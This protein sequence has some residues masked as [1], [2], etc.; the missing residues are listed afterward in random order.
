MS[1]SQPFLALCNGATLLIVSRIKYGDMP[2][3]VRLIISEGV[4][5][6]HATPWEYVN[7]ISCGDLSSMKLQKQNLKLLNLYGPTEITFG[8]SSA[9]ILY[10]MD[11]NL[12]TPMEIFPDCSIYIL[13]SKRQ[14]LLIGVPGEIH[15]GGAGVAEG[16]LNNELLNRERFLLDDHASVEYIENNWI[17]MHRSG[18]RGRLSNKGALIVEGRTD[19]DTQIKL[20][21]IR[22]DF[23]DI[24]STITQNV[25]G[26]VKQA[27]VSLFNSSSADKSFL[28]AHKFLINNSHK[29]DRKAIS[30]L[31]LSHKVYKVMAPVTISQFSQSQLID[32]WQQALG[33][34]IASHYVIEHNSN[35]F[36]VGGTSVGLIKLQCLIKTR[37]QV[38]VPLAQLFENL[39]L[40]SMTGKIAP[41]SVVVCVDNFP[42]KSM[43]NHRNFFFIGQ[44]GG[45]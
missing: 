45:V 34:E 36:Q 17:K 25:N 20:R 41:V 40:D 23:E 39:T 24:E 18:D 16:Y 12:Q 1:L 28:V 21:G 37:F 44:Q 35:L 29:V 31:P 5:F 2:A 33:T 3:I 14:P 32:L 9:E 26:A 22:F 8:M 6:T 43:A 30:G 13:N 4:T 38:E 10:L 7:W 27:V 15:I 11:Y 42:T 19:G